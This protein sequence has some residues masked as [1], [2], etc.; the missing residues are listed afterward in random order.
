MSMGSLG[1][2]GSIAGTPLAQAKGSDIDKAKSEVANQQRKTESVEKA[3]AASGIGVTQGDSETSDRD[4]DGRR[5]WEIDPTAKAKDEQA[6]DPSGPLPL[7][8]DPTG[9]SGKQIDLCG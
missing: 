1:L 4:A 6:I 7:S 5:I 8:K 9:N 2:I 3:D